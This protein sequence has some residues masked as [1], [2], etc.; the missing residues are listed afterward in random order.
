MDCSSPPADLNN[1]E[2]VAEAQV[3]LED[4]KPDSHSSSL[5]KVTSQHAFIQSYLVPNGIGG[6]V[7]KSS[8]FDTAFK[9]RLLKSPWTPDTT[10]TFSISGKRKLKFQL[11]WLIRFSWLSY[12]PS[13]DGAFCRLFFFSSEIADKGSHQRLGDLVSKAFRNWKDAIEC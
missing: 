11:G 10:Y 4:A 2:A 5:N 13:E 6:F 1:T 8:S 9:L 3:K 12:S 7:H